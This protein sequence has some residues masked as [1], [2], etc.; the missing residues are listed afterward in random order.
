MLS[1]SK[2]LNRSGFAQKRPER[3]PKPPATRSVRS[4]VYT[5]GVSGVAVEKT[6]IVRSEAYRRFV[7]SHACFGCGIAGFSQCAHEN[8]DKG[9]AMK[10]CDS[11]SWPMCGPRYGLIGC[12]AQFDLGIDSDR[13]ERRELG[14]RYVIRMQN[15]AM[16]AGWR[17][18]GWAILP[19][20]KVGA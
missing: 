3:T 13:E 19:P 17:F 12:H 18:P 9:M 8:L 1:R 14:A 15:I 4:G 2:P 6:P 11:R 16:A 10:V 5:G 7:A 20:A